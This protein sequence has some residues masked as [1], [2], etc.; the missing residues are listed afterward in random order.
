MVFSLAFLDRRIVDAGDAQPHEAVLI[1]LPVFVTIATEPMTAVVVPLVGKPH[2]NAVVADSK[3][4]CTVLAASPSDVRL[5]VPVPD[6]TAS[7]T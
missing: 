2:G 6:G 7:G 3:R 1:E 5:S 4:M